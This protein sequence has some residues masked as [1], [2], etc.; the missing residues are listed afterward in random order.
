VDGGSARLSPTV[1]DALGALDE[2]SS[3]G[4]EDP[5]KGVG[6]RKRVQ[7]RAKSIA[8]RDSSSKYHQVPKGTEKMFDANW[9][10]KAFAF[11]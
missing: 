2:T 7:R 11:E 3:V 6:P 5:E 10:S 1:I 9:Q 4:T 8:Q